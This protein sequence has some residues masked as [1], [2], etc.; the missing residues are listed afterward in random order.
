[1][2]IDKIRHIIVSVLFISIIVLVFVN[3]SFRIVT[4]NMDT[5]ENRAMAEKPELDIT[6]LDYFPGKY[7]AY[8]ND[9]FLLRADYVSF[10]LF[11]SQKIFH[12]RNVKGNYLIGK[13]NWVYEIRL[14]LSWYTGERTLNEHQLNKYKVEFSKRQ[15]YFNSRGTKM[16]ILVIPSKYCVYP[17]Y[18]PSV[19]RT[20]RTTWTDKFIKYLNEN[21]SVIIVDGRKSL[22]KRKRDQNVYLKYDTHWTMLGAFY[23]LSDLMDTIRMD[24]PS[25]PYYGLEDLNIDTI[26]R[27]DGNMRYAI[28]DHDSLCEPDYKITP[29]GSDIE[30]ISGYKHLKMDNFRFTQF[31]YCKRF[32]NNTS[33]DTLKAVIFRDSFMN[34]TMSF[35]PAYFREILYIWDN[36]QFRFNKD[37]ID[38]EKPDMVIYIFF[39]G[40][41]DRIL[42]DPSFVDPE[43]KLDEL[44]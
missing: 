19:L 44:E 7:D 3:Q 23:A 37:I 35:F 15:E 41:L 40:Y 11:L 5:H 33:Q 20:K 22:K 26:E 21:T 38:I 32:R 16:Y 6:S 39:E 4:G 13:D 1:M 42:V 14:N 8:Y 31:D 28:A 27:F 10:M 25:V 34:R 2:K 24:F 30:R 29:K 12:K 36:W 43:F 9:N 18:L 17:E